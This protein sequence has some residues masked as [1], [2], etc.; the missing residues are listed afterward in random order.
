MYTGCSDVFRLLIQ[1]GASTNECDD[2]RERT[3]DIVTVAWKAFMDAYVL[4][5]YPMG[6]S[7]EKVKNFEECVAMT[8]LALDNN[9]TIDSANPRV[10]CA[11]PLFSLVWS[12]GADID[13]SVLVDAITYL[14]SIGYDLEETNRI[15]QTPLLLAAAV[16]GPQIARCL[17]AL[18]GRGANLNARDDMGRGPLLSA[19]APPL[20]ISNWMDLTFDWDIG[21]NDCDNNWDLKEY[22]RT[23]DHRYVRDYYDAESIIDPLGPHISHMSRFTPSLDVEDRQ[24]SHDQGSSF[25]TE[26]LELV[27][28]AM[29]DIDSSASSCSE[30]PVSS[31]EDD[32][33]V[34][35]LDDEGDGV[36]IRNP[37]HVLKDRV[38]VKLKV[39]LEAG[40]DPN[41][42]DNDGQSTNDYARYGLWS[43]WL[44]ALNKTGYFF[45]EEQDRW[46]KRIDPA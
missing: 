3:T 6:L 29:S 35:A 10:I 7:V 41:D 45:D 30:K 15:G 38:R 5:L 19:L 40:C 4:G 25:T 17:D 27:G 31:P 26:Q 32:D 2:Y 18:V 9:C 23:D 8:Q 39:L 36:W 11:G 20:Y 16:C 13:A 24:L 44:W 21:G 22:F 28:L 12:N 43:Q 37:S 34:Y 42:F 14:L 46:V 33:Y 1:G